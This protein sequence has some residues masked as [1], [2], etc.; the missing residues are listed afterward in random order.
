[1]GAPDACGQQAG[2]RGGAVHLALMPP[3][4]ADDSWAKDTRELEKNASEAR[5]PANPPAAPLNM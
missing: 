3:L 1:M 2:D 4:R 5:L